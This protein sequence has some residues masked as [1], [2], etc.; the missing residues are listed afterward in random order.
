M[1]SQLPTD[2]WHK[3]VGDPTVAAAILD[4]IVYVAHPIKMQ[5]TRCE[6]LAPS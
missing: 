4:R 5:A 2:A 6:K 1:A 3:Y